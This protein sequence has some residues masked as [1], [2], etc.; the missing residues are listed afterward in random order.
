MEWT[1]YCSPPGA[2]DSL[3][4]FLGAGYVA[5]LRLQSGARLRE[6]QEGR[7]SLGWNEPWRLLSAASEQR[8]N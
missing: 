2:G 4:R 6:P 1:S 5:V 7:P 3:A 8:F